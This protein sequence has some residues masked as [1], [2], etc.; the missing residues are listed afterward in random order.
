MKIICTQENLRN[1]LQTVSRIISNS[2]TLPILNNVLMKTENGLLD[3]SATNL[4]VG[5]STVIRCK[6]EEEGS[7]CL[8]AKTFTDLVNNLPNTNITIQSRDGEAAVTTERYNTKIKTLPS[9]EFPLIP[10]IEN[11]QK[12][13]FDAQALK[14][15]VDSVVFA[16]STSETQ[17]EISGVLMSQSEDG[18]KFAATDRYRLAEKTLAGL[19]GPQKSIIIPHKTALELSRVLAGQ[20][21]AIDIIVTENQI[22]VTAGDTQLVSRLIDGQYPDYKQII[23][24]SF[25]ATVS[26]GKQ[27]FINALKTSGI[28]SRNTGSVAMK[29]D[30]AGQRLVVSSVS[31]DLGESTVELPAEVTGADGGIILNYRYVLEAVTA[32]AG[33]AIVIK[34]VNES[35]PVIFVPQ[36]DVSYIYLVMPIKS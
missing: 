28:F 26:V 8:P 14:Q 35:S 31:Q 9:E 13:T 22:G 1:G 34:V 4:E 15:A 19:A 32:M 30:Q 16:A 25:N 36:G 11:G 3:L 5:V 33:E 10:A 20:T 6:I 21:E 24:E 7:I 2:N 29:Y 27:D 18:I 17:P 12:I 23:P